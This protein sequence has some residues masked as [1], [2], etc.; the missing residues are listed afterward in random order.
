[1]G[2]TG[3]EPNIQRIRHFLV[4]IGFITQDVRNIK[5]KPGINTLLFDALGYLLDKVNPSTL[6]TNSVIGAPQVR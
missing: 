3:V 1:M 6:F 4:S 5:I 2:H